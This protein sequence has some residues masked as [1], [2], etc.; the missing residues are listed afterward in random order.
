MGYGL[1]FGVTV[2]AAV[3]GFAGPV[4]TITWG[5]ATSTH[6]WGDPLNQFVGLVL[7]HFQPPFRVPLD[8][9]FR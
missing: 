9:Q 5:G 8:K 3:A 1:G 4:D 6:F 7:S 2:D